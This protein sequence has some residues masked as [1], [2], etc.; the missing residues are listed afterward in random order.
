M[1]VL[2]KPCATAGYGRFQLESLLTPGNY[3]CDFIIDARVWCTPRVRSV[4]IVIE[5]CFDCR[6]A[7]F[8]AEHNLLEAKKKHVDAIF[9]L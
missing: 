3:G 4:C 1:Y 5:T 6:L 2:L 9:F 7:G 8:M